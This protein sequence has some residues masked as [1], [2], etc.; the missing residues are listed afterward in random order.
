MDNKNHETIESH[1]SYAEW[2]LPKLYFAIEKGD[3]EL[4]KLRLKHAVICIENLINGFRNK[5]K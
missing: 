5:G 4:T 1:L 2:L 3:L